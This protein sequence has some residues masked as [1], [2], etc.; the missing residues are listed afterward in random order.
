MI[1][2][3]EDCE[4]IKLFDWIK[5]RPDLEPFCFHVANERTCS[6][7]HGII[8]RRKGVKKGVFDNFIM[9]PREKWHG[10]ILELKSRKGKLSKEQEGFMF[11]MASQGYYCIWSSGF[12]QAK[13][14]IEEYLQK[15]SFEFSIQSQTISVSNEKDALEA[16]SNVLAKLDFEDKGKN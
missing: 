12:N 7:Q 10:M 6:P 16:E 14:A 5:S 8:L 3:E 1:L 9:I 15:P 13:K 2:D 11:D 4:Q